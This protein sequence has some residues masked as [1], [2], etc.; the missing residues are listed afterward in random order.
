MTNT[1]ICKQASPAIIT[2][3]MAHLSGALALLLS[4]D[5][6]NHTPL[7][8]T[9]VHRF[10]GVLRFVV[11]D[12][13]DEAE[14]LGPSVAGRNAHTRQ[15]IIN[16]TRQGNISPVSKSVC[17]FVL[18]REMAHSELRDLL[19][20]SARRSQDCSHTHE[21]DTTAGGGARGIGCNSGKEDDHKATQE[22]VEC[23]HAEAILIT[24]ASPQHLRNHEAA[25]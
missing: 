8:L 21:R 23:L 18:L 12:E 22:N 6:V 19:H 13:F 14:G 1:I 4:K 5:N 3:T 24:I 2:I 25:A 11:V 7:E 15:H 9:A 20:T 10:L 16:L 17:R